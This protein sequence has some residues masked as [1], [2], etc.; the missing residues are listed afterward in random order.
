MQEMQDEGVIFNSIEAEITEKRITDAEAALLQSISK[1]Y[2]VQHKQLFVDAITGKCYLQLIVARTTDSG[3]QGNMFYI[4]VNS[5]LIKSQQTP[6]PLIY[7]M[8]D[9]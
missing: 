3:Y 6:P 1:T 2:E 9:G 4:N 7:R 8:Y 5:P